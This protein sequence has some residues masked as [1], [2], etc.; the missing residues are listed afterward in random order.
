[1]LKWLLSQ[2]DAFQPASGAPPQELGRFFVWSLAGSRKAIMLGAVSNIVLGFS[3]LVAAAFTG[4]AIDTALQIGP[5]D[6]GA[7]W[8]LFLVAFVFFMII[9]PVLFRF[10]QCCDQ[11]P[12]GAASFSADPVADQ[13]SHAGPVAP[14]F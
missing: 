13:P 6:P 3:E 2:I 5:G 11:H 4:W 10:Q 14:F 9:R 7:L 8:P 1:M 12:S